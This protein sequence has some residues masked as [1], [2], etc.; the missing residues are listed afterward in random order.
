MTSNL[1][2]LPATAPIATFVPTLKV[3]SVALILAAVTAPSA[4]L[5]VVTPSVAPVESL[6]L[7]VVT[8]LSA[9]CVTVIVPSA[10]DEALT[11]PAASLPLVIPPSFT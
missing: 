9:N 7:G 8:A 6:I 2:V 5:A 10:I 3:V 1:K 4:I 11:A